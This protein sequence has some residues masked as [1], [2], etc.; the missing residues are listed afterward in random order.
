MNRPPAH[1]GGD[2]DSSSGSAGDAANPCGVSRTLEQRLDDTAWN[3]RAVE[4]VRI[5]RLIWDL[6]E[7]GM[8]MSADR[9]TAAIWAARD[10]GEE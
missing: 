7:K 4:R 8:P 2:S 6:W 10:E 3:A 9:I 1:D 5:V